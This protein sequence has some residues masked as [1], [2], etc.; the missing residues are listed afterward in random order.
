LYSLSTMYDELVKISKKISPGEKG[1]AVPVPQS[2]LAGLGGAGLVA[3]TTGLGNALMGGS[4]SRDVSNS[5]LRTTAEEAEKLRGTIHPHGGMLLD[6][7]LLPTQAGHVDRRGV[8]KPAVYNQLERAVRTGELSKEELEK[9]MQG[10]LSLASPYGGAH[11]LAHELGH[12]HL[13]QSGL[14]KVIA[15][16][17]WPGVAV[18]GLGGLVASTA[19][20]PDSPVSKYAPLAGALGVAPMMA[21]EAYASLKGY[22]AMK[23]LGYDPQAL[24]AARRQLGKAFGTYGLGIAAPLIATPFAVRK[25]KQKLKERQARRAAAE[26]AR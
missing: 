3:Q 2:I 15:G 23:R 21:D 10:G 26:L 8:R 17:R 7:Y 11:F 9:A 20:D 1:L 16:L 6:K 24:S 19:A 25:I 14:G 13:R 12:G 5:G 22:G 4:L 18:G